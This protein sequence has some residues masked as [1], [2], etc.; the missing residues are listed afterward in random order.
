MVIVSGPTASYALHVYCRTLSIFGRAQS[1]PLDSETWTGRRVGCVKLTYA[2]RLAASS[3]S[4]GCNGARP[5]P[6]MGVIGRSARSTMLML[7]PRWLTI[8]CSLLYSR[9]SVNTLTGSRSILASA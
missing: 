1:Y 5:L 6:I 2:I 4:S 7:S 8:P 3:T 9:P